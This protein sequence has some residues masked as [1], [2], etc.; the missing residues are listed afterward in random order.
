MDKLL[1]YH[2][3]REQIEREYGSELA[4]NLRMGMPRDYKLPT[5]DEQD[6]EISRRYW[7]AV[8]QY[9]TEN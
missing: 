7:E 5:K 6:A 1:D 9:N 4:K 3:L 2:T 8:E